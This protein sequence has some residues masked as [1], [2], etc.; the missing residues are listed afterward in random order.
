MGEA[1]NVGGGLLTELFKIELGHGTKSFK[2]GLQGRRGQGSN[3]VGVGVN[4][5]GFEGIGVN[6]EDVGV[7][8]RG[9]IDGGGGRSK[10]RK[11]GD[12][13]LRAGGNGG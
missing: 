1:D 5:T 7:G 10:K 8:G 6:E 4:G 3:D 2:G 13:E 11:A 9:G 12:D